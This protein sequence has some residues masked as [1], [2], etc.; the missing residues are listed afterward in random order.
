LEYQ[1]EVL[2]Q[3]EQANKLAGDLVT[4]STQLFRGLHW[5]LRGRYGQGTEVGGLAKSKAALKDA[6]LLV[7][8]NMPA[9]PPVP[10]DPTDKS[11]P[12]VPR[13]ERRHH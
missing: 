5:W 7:W 12:N 10:N 8:L 1:A 2:A 11:T 13:F 9:R 6:Q 3:S 4:K